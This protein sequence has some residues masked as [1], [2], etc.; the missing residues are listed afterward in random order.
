MVNSAFSL[1]K[2]YAHDAPIAG[3]VQDSR[4]DEQSIRR[5]LLLSRQVT[6]LRAKVRALEPLKR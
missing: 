5:M 6:W 4:V 1:L 2:G 3:A